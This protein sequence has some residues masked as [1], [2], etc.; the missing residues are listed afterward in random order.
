MTSETE[1]T[2]PRLK[3]PPLPHVGSISTGSG[4]LMGVLALLHIPVSTTSV[5][6]INQLALWLP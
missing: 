4:G 1:E 6:A 5:K 2:M 3:T